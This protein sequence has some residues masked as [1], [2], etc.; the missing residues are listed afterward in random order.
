M[1]DYLFG[2]WGGILILAAVLAIFSLLFPLDSDKNEKRPASVPAVEHHYFYP[3]IQP[4]QKS[5][6]RVS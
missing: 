4:C 3:P 6:D 5:S 1:S 2:V